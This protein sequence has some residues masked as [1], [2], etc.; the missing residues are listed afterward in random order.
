MFGYEPGRIVVNQGETV[1]FKLKSEDVTH[2]FYIDGYDVN[3]KVHFGQD[4]T[5]TIVADK[6]GKF[7]IRC[8]STCGPLHPFMVGEL[9]VEQSGVNT[10][11]L[12]SAGLVS[13]IGVLTLIFVYRRG[14]DLG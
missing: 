3:A 10:V 9:V 13:L 1:T 11:F 8:S 4:E 5:V 14:S 2:G 7:K 6:P 12:G